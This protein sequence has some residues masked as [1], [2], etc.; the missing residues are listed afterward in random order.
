[1]QYEVKIT[2]MTTQMQSF[3][4]ERS[5]FEDV[6]RENDN[7]KRKVGELGQAAIKVN[8]YELKIEM[9]AR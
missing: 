9:A 8:E 4:R 1:M 7:L 6:K 2:R 5:E 3:E